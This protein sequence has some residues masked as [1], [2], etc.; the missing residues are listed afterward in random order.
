MAEPCATR[1]TIPQL[2][3][4]LE[5]EVAALRSLAAMAVPRGFAVVAPS[6]LRTE[7]ERASLSPGDLARLTEAPRQD[8]EDWLAARIPT[9]AWVLTTVQ[10][11]ALL[12]PSVRRKLLRQPIGPAATPTLT[13]HPFSRIEDL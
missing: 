11:A 6:L 5:I 4:A 10:L 8:V 7:M 9:P 12:T 2:L 3:D 13:I 1:A